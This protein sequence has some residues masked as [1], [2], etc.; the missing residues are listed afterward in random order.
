M[1]YRNVE[2]FT[3]NGLTAAQ[4]K[5]LLD[6]YDLKAPARHGDVSIS[7]FARR[8]RTRRSCASSTSARAASPSR[9]S[10]AATRT[11]SPPRS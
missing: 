11:C 4:F 9:A 6:R 7:N 10:A 3:F 5:A 8:W 2:P 1:G